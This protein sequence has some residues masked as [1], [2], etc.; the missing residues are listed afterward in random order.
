MAAALA[1]AAIT[2]G[3]SLLGGILGGD[4]QQ[5]E[6]AAQQKL[7]KQQLAL[8]QAQFATGLASQMQLGGLRDQAVY[9][10]NNM[11]GQSPEAFNPVNYGAPTNEGQQGVGGSNLNQEAQVASQ[12]TPGAGGTNTNVAQAALGMLGYNNQS[13]IQQPNNGGSTN[14]DFAGTNYANGTGPQASQTAGR[15]NGYTLSSGTSAFSPAGSTPGGNNYFPRTPGSPYA[16]LGYGAGTA[17]S[18]PG[19]SGYAGYAQRQ[20]GGGPTSAG[21]PTASRPGMGASQT[22]G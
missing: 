10:L 18:G 3:T 14:Y 21:W 20:Q 1:P 17:P 22:W 13:D 15:Q 11:M 9:Q 8:Q 5:Q 19:A 2:A 4:A 12:Y 16:G 7:Q 6:F